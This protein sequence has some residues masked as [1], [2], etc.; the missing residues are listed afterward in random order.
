MLTSAKMGKKQQNW[1]SKLDDD[2]C[3]QVCR[4]SG[5]LSSCLSVILHAFWAPHRRCTKECASFF[6]SEQPV[7]PMV[8]TILMFSIFHQIA[9]S[10]PFVFNLL[11]RNKENASL[12]LIIVILL[13]L[14][15]DFRSCDLLTFRSFLSLDVLAKKPPYV[16]KNDESGVLSCRSTKI[17][18]SNFRRRL[19]HD[20]SEL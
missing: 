7:C 2:C 6:S 15:L 20:P 12:N 11:V 5:C 16:S 13:T 3:L 9:K 17:Y 8:D 4:Y 19:R 1:F 14:F 10:S 18:W